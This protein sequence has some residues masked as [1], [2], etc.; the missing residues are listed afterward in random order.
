MK[1]SHATNSCPVDDDNQQM[2]ART[3]LSLA[4]SDAP[5]WNGSKRWAG[6]SMGLAALPF[7]QYERKGTPTNRACSNK[8]TKVSRSPTE[9]R[10]PMG[11]CFKLLPRTCIACC[12]APLCSHTCNPLYTLCEHQLT[13]TKANSTQDS[14]PLALTSGTVPCLNR[15][16]CH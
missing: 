6:T 8:C 11:A 12:I 10:F 15:S 14:E 5:A 13:A 7:P 3:P 1:Q 16:P 9:T 2:V 4:I